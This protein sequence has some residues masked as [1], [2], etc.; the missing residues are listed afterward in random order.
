MKYF[1][2]L[3]ILAFCNIALSKTKNKYT[4]TIIDTN[5]RI[6]VN[7]TVKVIYDSDTLLIETNSKG[8]ITLTIKYSFPCT[9]GSRHRIFGNPLRGVSPTYSKAPVTLIY[10]GKVGSFT[11]NWNT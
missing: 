9:T 1:T 5:H 4:D 2:L 8:E 11:K 7:E 6:L 3:T 10:N